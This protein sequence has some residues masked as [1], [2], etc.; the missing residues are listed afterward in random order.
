MYVCSRGAL[1]FKGDRTVF[2]RC[3][4]PYRV[5]LGTAQPVNPLQLETSLEHRLQQ[6]DERHAWYVGSVSG[7]DMVLLP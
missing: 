4:S 3:V 5:S 7:L 6:G 1:A 2:L